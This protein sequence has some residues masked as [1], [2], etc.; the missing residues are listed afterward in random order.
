[1]PTIADGPATIPT[2]LMAAVMALPPDTRRELAEQALASLHT[3]APLS[4]EWKEEIA[5]RLKDQDEGRA[6]YY[7]LEETMEHL[8]RVAVEEGRS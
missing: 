5:R 1:M 4:P 6:R 2:E 8:R 7:T 3:P